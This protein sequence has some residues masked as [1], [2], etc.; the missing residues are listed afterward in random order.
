MEVTWETKG[1][2]DSE[3]YNDNQEKS[4]V[5]ELPEFNL[6]TEAYAEN[7]RAGKH[8][9]AT[10]GHFDSESYS[11]ELES[12]E[13]QSDYAR[14]W[15]YSL[16][17]PEMR[18]KWSRM[19]PIDTATYAMNHQRGS[20]LIPVWSLIGMWEDLGLKDKAEKLMYGTYENE[21]D[22]QSDLEDIKKFALKLE[23]EEYRGFT[24]TAQIYGILSEAP[25]LMIEVAVTMGWGAGAKK[26]G[27]MA[28]RK[29]IKE[30]IKTTTKKSLKKGLLNAGA[31]TLKGL[32][33]ISIG[34][35]TIMAPRVGMG[36]AQRRLNDY[37]SVTDKGELILKAA[38]ESPAMALFKAYS[39]VWIEAMVEGVGG[40]LVGKG[41]GLT[42][43][44]PLKWAGKKALGRLDDGVVKAF[45]AGIPKSSLVKFI[46]ASNRKLAYN[47]I[48]GEY[49]EERLSGVFNAFTGLDER[50]FMKGEDGKIRNMTM[51]D[52]YMDALFPSATQA[53]IEIGAF[54]IMSMG[55]LT[56]R[57]IGKRWKSRG[58]TEADIRAHL[59]TKSE[60]EKESILEE[61]IRIH[62]ESKS[63]EVLGMDERPLE[64][65]EFRGIQG[66]RLNKIAELKEEYKDAVDEH[67][68]DSDEAIAIYER[69][70]SE[71]EKVKSLDINE[72]LEI[73]NKDREELVEARGK[74]KVE[75][76]ESETRERADLEV[77]ARK[78]QAK[79]P[80]EDITEPSVETVPDFDP[81]EQGSKNIIEG[82]IAQGM[83]REEAIEQR[84]SDVKETQ[85]W[86]DKNTQEGDR[87]TTPDG[88]TFERDYK[89]KWYEVLEGEKYA[90][91]SITIMRANLRGGTLVRKKAEKPKAK[92]KA[93]AKKTGGIQGLSKA[94]GARLRKETGLSE[95]DKPVRRK[96]ET[97][98]KEADPKFA[99][100]L[101]Q[102]VI[103]NPRPLSDKE[104]AS[105][106]V[107]AAELANEHE[108]LVKKGVEQAEAGSP[109]A[110]LS[111]RR[112][113]EI[114]E[115]IET[116]T[117]ATDVAGT[118]A[119]RALSIRRMMIN[120]ESFKL[121]EVIRRASQRKGEVLTQEEKV[122]FNALVKKL[123]ALETNVE[124]LK[125][126]LEKAEERASKA[127]AEK[128]V[129][130]T[131]SSRK[132]DKSVIKK[133]RD[134]IKKQLQALGMRVNDITGLSVDASVIVGKLASTY[135]REGVV[136]LDEVVKNVLRDV[137]DIS[138]R[139]VWDAISGRGRESRKK[140][141]SEVE[142]RLASIK[143][144]ASLLSEIED[145]EKGL[146]EK[147]K[148]KSTDKEV[149]NLRKKLN[150][151][152]DEVM[153]G[154][155]DAKR[156]DAIIRKI[157]EI[158]DDIEA[159]VIRQTEKKKKGVD[160]APIAEAKKKLQELRSLMKIDATL[161]DLMKQLET[162]E[163]KIQPKREVRIVSS[164]LESARAK[165]SMAKKE[166]RQRIRDQEPMTPLRAISE[167]AQFARTIKAT[168]D[169]SGVLR[170][171]AWMASR[172]PKKAAKTLV[173]AERAAWSEEYYHLIDGQL[174]TIA[175][176]HGMIE[177][178]LELTET[179]GSLTN[180]EED[181]A[182]D[183]AERIPGLGAVI[184]NSNRHM[185]TYLNM[186]RVES[187]KRFLTDNPNATKE[188]KQTYA[189][190]INVNSGRGDLG[191]LDVML[192]GLGKLFF[193]PRF[194]ISRI[195]VGWMA[196]KE[197]VGA[198]KSGDW[199]IAK[200]IGKDFGA[201][202]GI[203]LAIMA[204]LAATFDDDEEN[205]I[206]WDWN[207][208][209]FG[210]VVIG[211]MR[212]DPWSGHAQPLRLLLSVADGTLSPYDKDFD[213]M[214]DIGRFL[215]YKLSPAVSTSS[216]LMSGKDFLGRE[217]ARSEIVLK[218]LLPIIVETAIETIIDGRD[219]EVIAGT[220]G[221]ELFG[222]GVG[223][224]D[225]AQHWKRGTRTWTNDMKEAFGDYEPGRPSLST[226]ALN[227]DDWTDAEKVKLDR[228]YYRLLGERIAVVLGRNQNPSRKQLERMSGS[229]RNQAR[230]KFQR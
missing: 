72:A 128:T 135:V 14:R 114:A 2:F 60:I 55:S 229:S 184:K 177:L 171:A 142:K 25:A 176:E 99:E 56:A 198:V 77:E 175:E 81:E 149:K 180:R 76:T 93:P 39:S 70:I 168:A 75:A 189:K 221:A 213:P 169:R 31:S 43:G 26:V 27:Q 19:G 69:T 28:I 109:N 137:P 194:A 223:V 183:Y 10:K 80:V 162:G 144:Q 178:G 210:K 103:N 215:M 156:L 52:K 163:F 58:L 20:D 147:R 95:L 139:D 59:D 218:A 205:Y 122:E 132:A 62:G 102:E 222:I 23:E 203:R 197:I 6:D 140:V 200:E 89:G 115:Q 63:D 106:V 45:L 227:T 219:G 152:R 41:L 167:V 101:A 74:A 107:R 134:E 172:M 34:T 155:R 174:R 165:V 150:A 118:E 3:S 21:A 120:R 186:M 136:T 208:S 73:E 190:F 188:Q 214:G 42:V 121:T 111:F 130:R 173:E 54:S 24:A 57:K 182:S 129:K 230:K 195:Q 36:Y 65:E 67:G 38:Q 33:R 49:G 196:G 123:E 201:Y 212:L 13:E 91:T 113:D 79:K 117:R 30:L 61:D 16:S 22:R 207:D 15:K 211:P 202:V 125:E 158:R 199:M 68:Q 220:I 94:E 161:K 170:Q 124:T 141:R 84:N 88:R 44:D 116:L 11:Q 204:I 145:A 105:L 82:Y 143:K 226:K 119:G 35:G 98:L 40:R 78:A 18:K 64:M 146:F 216:S 71:I 50:K 32:A 166:I 53:G 108:A 12:Y 151:L 48:I 90:S 5:E 225:P 83:T 66:E 112:A 181:F 164:E 217:Q 193:A 17:T 133:D 87:I 157:D 86:V 7:I 209:D 131:K 127:E 159:G 37:I 154:E 206:G 47:G 160:S 187:M 110:Q 148:V 185:V 85:D 46:T 179:G 192:G 96:W 100:S 104:H 29:S 1:N 191:K 228:Y 224:Y 8:D 138:A 97:A 51:Y 4:P 92:K 9:W 126:S 153:R